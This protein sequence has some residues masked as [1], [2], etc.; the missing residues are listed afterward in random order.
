M[1]FLGPELKLTR[2][3]GHESVKALVP[4]QSPGL[5]LVGF[6]EHR[7]EQVHDLVL[8]EAAHELRPR[9]L[10]HVND[11]LGALVLAVVVNECEDELGC[12][13]GKHGVVDHA[14]LIRLRF[15]KN[16]RN[17]QVRETQELV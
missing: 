15:R 2:A 9:G 12:L 1:N 13:S 3:K 16:D 14:R 4:T 11:G 7:R 10:G 5:V 8:V 6:Q 17:L